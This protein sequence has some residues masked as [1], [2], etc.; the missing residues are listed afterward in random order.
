MREKEEKKTKTRT[1]SKM[2]ACVCAGSICPVSLLPHDR[3][4]LYILGEENGGKK[5]IEKWVEGEMGAG[6]EWLFSSCVWRV[7]KGM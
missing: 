5:N 7:C 6:G 1:P 3:K 2:R 4:N